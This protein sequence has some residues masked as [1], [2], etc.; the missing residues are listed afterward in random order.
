MIPFITCEITLVRMSASWFFGVDVLHLYFW[1]QINS[2]EQPIER[3]SVG[4]GNMSLC[5]TPSFNVILITASMSSNT[6]NI[7]SWCEHWMFEGTRSMLFG[8]LIFPWD[9]WLL[10]ITTCRT[11]L[12][13]VRVMFPKTVTIRYHKSRAGSPSNLDPAS[14]VMVSDSVELCETEV[15]FLHIQLFGRS[16][17]ILNPQDPLQNQS[18]E[19]VPICIV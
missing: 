7:A 17:W 5:G 11:G 8:T 13:V 18:L 12:S 10:S 16:V 2:I 6:Y 3:N 4:P 1:V 14:R 19:P 9:R 15:C